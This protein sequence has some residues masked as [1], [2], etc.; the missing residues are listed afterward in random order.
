[1]ENKTETVDNTNTSALVDGK[2]DT[3]QVDPM[4]VAQA[5]IAFMHVQNAELNLSNKKLLAENKILE[6]MALVGV[7]PKEYGYNP[8]TGELTKQ[9]PQVP[10]AQEPAVP[11]VPAV[12]VANK[13]AESPTPAVDG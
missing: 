13:P 12:L 3:I 10:V 2:P 6:I 8:N 11:A 9:K 4:N 7:S 5:T 1:M